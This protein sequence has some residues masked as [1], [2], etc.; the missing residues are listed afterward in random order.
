MAYDQLEAVVPVLPE[1][2]DPILLPVPAGAVKVLPRWAEEDEVIRW[3][4]KYRVHEDGEADLTA[5]AGHLDD[6]KQWV[7]LELR[8]FTRELPLTGLMP[9][10]R[11]YFKVAVETPDGWSSWSKTCSCVPPSPELPGKPAAVFAV[12]QDATSALV[13]WTRP[14]DFAAAV[15]CGHIRRYK[16]L[17]TWHPLDESEDVAS[18]FREIII[19]GDADCCE[20]TDLQCLRNYRFQVAAEN[21]TGWGDYSDESQV[22]NVPPTVPQQLPPPT[23]RKATHYG[24]VIQ[25]NQPPASEIPIESFRFRYTPSADFEGKDVTEIKDVPPNRTQF[26]VDGLKPGTTYLFQ[27]TSLNKYGMGVWSLNSLPLR[28][29]E[30]CEPSKIVGL[31]VPHV[32]SSFITLQWPPAAENGFPVTKH[33]LRFSYKRD[34]SEATELEP[35]V[36]RKDGVERTDLRHLRKLRYFFQIACCNVKGM[37]EWSDPVEVDLVKVPRLEDA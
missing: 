22:L 7:E 27:A 9:G 23:L 24:A 37:S 1:A 15:S 17:I 34:M 21:V 36:E 16:L 14:I 5:T 32:Y 29:L 35:V 12:V 28:T 25:W 18:C 2:A 8:P 4:V 31:N 33:L 11:H 10:R 30:G 20:V 3:R 6:G 19:E 13:R 26:I